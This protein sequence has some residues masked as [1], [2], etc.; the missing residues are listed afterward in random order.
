MVIG[1]LS[2]ELENRASDYLRPMWR[3][4]LRPNAREHDKNG[5]G[6]AI[7]GTGFPGFTGNA[8]R[9]SAGIRVFLEGMVAMTH[10][11]Q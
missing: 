3:T 5:V 7:A 10:R 2:R 1:G 9:H 11:T 6:K 8:Y 4:P